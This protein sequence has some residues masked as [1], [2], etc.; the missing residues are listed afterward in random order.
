MKLHFTV[1]GIMVLLLV[2][3]CASLRNCGTKCD[4]KIKYDR[5]LEYDL[6]FDYVYMKTIDAMNL[7][8]NWV[9][10]E[11]DKEKGIVVLRNVQFG[12]IFDRDKNV[13]HVNVKRVSRK[14]TTVA[15]D[16]DSQELPQGGEILNKIDEIMKRVQKEDVV[17]EAPEE[18][19]PAA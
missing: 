15:L 11:T 3:G 2:S 10:E 5:V 4:E 9:L 13:A 19:P 17:S 6:P 12:H 1:L 7:I 18:T 14:H 8:P 16:P